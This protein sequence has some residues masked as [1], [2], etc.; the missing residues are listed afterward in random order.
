V[1]REDVE[2]L[3][4]AG[5]RVE[6]ANLTATHD[7]PTVACVASGTVRG[8]PLRA[9][10]SAADRTLAR[11]GSRAAAEAAAAYSM[12][13]RRLLTEGDAGPLRFTEPSDNA[14][15]YLRPDRQGA[16]DRIF[17]DA[18]DAAAPELAGTPQELA[19]EL[20]RR[21]AVRRVRTLAADITPRWQRQRG[22]ATVVTR[23]PDLFPFE[24]GP[25]DPGL[26]RRLVEHPSRRGLDKCLPDA[27]PLPLA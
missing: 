13:V 20:A 19:A 25:G 5:L 26:A 12:C 16:L 3:T 1:I 6:L 11:A 2:R 23:S 17:A 24:V 10:G 18:E 21:L 14:F 15:Y 22:L 7:V 4:R 9:M 8:R 27:S